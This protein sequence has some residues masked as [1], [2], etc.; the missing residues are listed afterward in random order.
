MGALPPLQKPGGSWN[1]PEDWKW[2]SLT[3]QLAEGGDKSA[4]DGLELVVGQGDAMDPLSDAP[5][6]FIDPNGEG[7]QFAV[8]QICAQRDPGKGLITSVI[9]LPCVP[10]SLGVAGQ[11]RDAYSRS[12]DF[13]GHAPG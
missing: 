7:H 10:N 1:V 13:P 12:R 2:Q 6:G 11:W 9:L 8:G 5:H 3:C 4:G